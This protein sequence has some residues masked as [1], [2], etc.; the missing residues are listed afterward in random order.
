MEE[1]ELPQAGQLV[2]GRLQQIVPELVKAVGHLVR[3]RQG[4]VPQGGWEEGQHLFQGGLQLVGQ[5]GLQFLVGQLV[6]GPVLEP[7]SQALVLP[8]EAGRRGWSGR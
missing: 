7:G 4:I 5:G 8:L 6:G 1:L 2:S 3:V